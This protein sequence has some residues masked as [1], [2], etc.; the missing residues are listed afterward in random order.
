MMTNTGHAESRLL[1][2]RLRAPRQS[3]D[4]SRDARWAEKR[5]IAEGWFDVIRLAERL[6]REQAGEPFM[7]LVR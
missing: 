2:D 7:R 3:P 4:A 5:R 1:H 6:R